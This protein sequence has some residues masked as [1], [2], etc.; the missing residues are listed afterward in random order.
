MA[1]LWAE[2]GAARPSAERVRART[3]LLAMPCMVLPPDG[4]GEILKQGE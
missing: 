2:S 4:G 3:V 1:P